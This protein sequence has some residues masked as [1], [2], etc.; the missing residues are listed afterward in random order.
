VNELLPQ[1]RA[2]LATTAPRWLHLATLPMDLLRRPPAP[3]EWSAMEC[4]RHLRDTEQDVFPCRVRA[5]LEGRDL[6]PYDPDAERR[7]DTDESSVALAEDF[8]RL[9]AE[10]L[11]LL[12]QVPTADLNREVHHGEYGQ[13]RLAELLHEWAAHDLMHTVQAE[14]ALM[15][16]FIAGSG[17]WR[18]SFAAHD[19]DR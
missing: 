18:A 12:R 16:P 5:F 17:P 19:V 11:S 2:V 14:Q 3:G 1:V 13:V 7:Q 9:R 10:S 4:L 8:A 6:V 15:Q